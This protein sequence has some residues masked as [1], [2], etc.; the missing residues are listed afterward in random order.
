MR[1]LVTLVAVLSLLL[2]AHAIVGGH[3]ADDGEYPWMA[4]LYN[5]ADPEGQYCGGS[6]VMPDR[7]VTAAHCVE[8]LLGIDLVDQVINTAQYGEFR[9]MLGSNSLSAGGDEISVL[10]IHVHP[11]YG[12]SGTP[13][14]AVLTLAQDADQQPI[15]WATPADA[16]LFAPGTRATVTGWGALSENGPYPDALHEVVVPIISDQE[17]EQAYGGWLDAQNEICAGYKQGGRDACYG[18][19]GGPLMVPDGD[20]LLLVG[21]VSWGDG[22]AQPGSPGVYA[23]VAAFSGFIGQTF[24]EDLLSGPV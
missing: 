9:V 18:D 13:D 12:L 2:P 7:V 6:L 24:P 1:W 14:V 23:E 19:S 5:G 22:C 3:E 4:A 16:P 11:D 8:G 21:L 15:R 10:F 20:D 17:C